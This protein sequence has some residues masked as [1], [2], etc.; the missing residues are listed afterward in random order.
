MLNKENILTIAHF[1]LCKIL[2]KHS[3]CTT[4]CLICIDNVIEVIP[5]YT[6]QVFTTNLHDIRIY[7]MD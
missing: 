4:T 7:F 5:E 2:I 3:K 1:Y 6:V